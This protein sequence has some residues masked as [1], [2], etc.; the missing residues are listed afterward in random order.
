MIQKFSMGMLRAIAAILFFA[1]AC[2]ILSGCGAARLAYGNGESLSYWWFDGYVDFDLEQESAI[3]E[4]IAELFA[5]HRE[6][7][8]PEYVR[9]L[10]SVEKR[11]QRDVTL[12]EI[13]ADVADFRRRLRVMTDRAAPSLADLALS[14]SPDQL[15]HLQEK[16]V[17]KNAAY[18]KQN[19]RGD[20]EERQQ[21]RYKKV[22]EQAEYWFGDFTDE[23]EARIRAASDAR[24]L[25]PELVYA[26][27]LQRQT[28]MV[29]MLQ[30]IQAEKPDRNMAIKLISSY[31][32][33]ERQRL[34][35]P[36]R[37]AF[38]DGLNE[39]NAR[40]AVLIIN[41][42]TPAQRAKAIERVR[43]WR[44]DFSKMSRG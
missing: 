29:T 44:T 30:K 8:L 22:L 10:A 1:M 20:V 41:D 39:S 28:A 23:Q 27:R 7:Q 13:N 12:S 17:S 37:K 25:N 5:W 2:G 19:L 9:L 24:P 15:V 16:F 18:R 3:K 26:D 21:R 32:D 43:Q 40:L 31:T 34:A 38:F 14:M 6:T 36:E 33:I 35:I 42:A 11:L 4:D